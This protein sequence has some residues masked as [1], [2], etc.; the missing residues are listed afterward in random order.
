MNF[1]QTVTSSF[2]ELNTQLADFGLHPQDWVLMPKSN[3]TI[4]IQHKE[5]KTFFFLGEVEK[6]KGKPYWKTIH[7]AGL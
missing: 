5:E 7:L 3:K 4:K 2:G 1:F 6:Q